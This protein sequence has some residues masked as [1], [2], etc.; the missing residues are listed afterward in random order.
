MSHFQLSS[1]LSHVGVLTE[2][3]APITSAQTLAPNNIT[4]TKCLR[5]SRLHFCTVGGSP[6]MPFI[7]VRGIAFHMFIQIHKCYLYQS[8]N[9]R[10]LVTLTVK[11]ETKLY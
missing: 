6:D 3:Q 4:S 11:Y 8:I 7:Y 2:T 9:I 1:L 10:S 5:V